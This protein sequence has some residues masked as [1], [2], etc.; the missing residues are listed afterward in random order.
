MVRLNDGNYVISL[1]LVDKNFIADTRVPHVNTDKAGQ[2]KAHANP[3]Q[4]QPA[5]INETSYKMRDS[6]RYFTVMV[7]TTLDC[8]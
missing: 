3:H 8:K 6:T 5:H 2:G 1:I 4:H 7:L